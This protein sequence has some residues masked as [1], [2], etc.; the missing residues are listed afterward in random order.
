MRYPPPRRWREIVPGDVI[1]DHNGIARRVLA[2]DRTDDPAQRIILVEGLPP[3]VVREW[4]F[5]AV[6]E[7]DAADAAANLLNAHLT[8]TPIDAKE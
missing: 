7:L 2:N 4:Q 1:M 8:A 5:I 3:A 6:V